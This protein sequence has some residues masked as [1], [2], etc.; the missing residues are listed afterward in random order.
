MGP[1]DRHVWRICGAGAAPWPRGVRACGARQCGGCSGNE[2]SDANIQREEIDPIHL[3]SA[4]CL[5]AAT[6]L[7][8][9]ALIWISAGAIAA[10]FDQ[11]CLRRS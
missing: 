7:A 8:I 6:G 10:A 3:G 4:F 2:G 9:T 1:T 11:P 5:L